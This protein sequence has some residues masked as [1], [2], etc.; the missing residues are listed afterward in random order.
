MWGINT[1][2]KIESEKRGSRTKNK[3]RKVEKHEMTWID[4]D[5]RCHSVF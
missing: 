3:T 1:E 5:I 4:I 2:Q